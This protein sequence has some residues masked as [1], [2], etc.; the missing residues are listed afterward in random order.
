MAGGST[1]DYTGV[2]MYTC[3]GSGSESWSQQPAA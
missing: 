3:N 1:S 2:G